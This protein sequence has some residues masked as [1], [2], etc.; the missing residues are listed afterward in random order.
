MVGDTVVID[1]TCLKIGRSMAFTECEFR[2]KGD[3]TLI[4]KGKHNLAFLN[5]LKKLDGQPV[6]Q[7]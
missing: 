2:K 3:N 1:A 7:F 4:A 5:H 6:N